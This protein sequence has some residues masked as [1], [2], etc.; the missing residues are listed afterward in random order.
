[1]RCAAPSTNS[2]LESRTRLLRLFAAH[3]SHL[4]RVANALL[5]VYREANRSAR[6][7]PPP[8][9]F[10]AI[11]ALEKFPVEQE[12]PQPSARDD[13]RR[14]IAESQSVLVGQVEAIHAEFERAFQTYREIDELIEEK[15]VVRSNAKAA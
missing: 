11:Y 10:S 3:Q 12:L 13:L 14:S 1:M 9:R 7:T 8:A 4:D 15:A 6:N 2:I 5:A